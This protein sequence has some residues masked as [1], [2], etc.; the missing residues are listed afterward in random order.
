M[1]S[2][3]ISRIDAHKHELSKGQRK[4]TAYIT[5]HYDKAAF[6]TAAK[7]G[8]TVGVSES[9]V[10]RFADKLGY[11][12]YHKM[13]K[14]LHEMIRT[15]LTSVQRIEV[16]NDRIGSTDVLE[17]VMAADAER[18]RSTLGEID[19]EAFNTAVDKLVS[20]K[21]I[22]IIGVRSAA[23]LASFLGFYFNSIFANVTLISTAT[24]SE[25]FE[26]LL[27]IGEGDVALGISFPR[28]S[29]RTVSALRF[30]K[31]RGAHVIGITDSAFSPIA[32]TSTTT[33]IA[34]SDMASFVDS[35]CAPLSLIN[36]LIVAIGM[37]KS[38][39]ISQT[40]EQLE[41]IWD[42]YNVYQKTQQ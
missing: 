32:E 38:D 16:T 9:T 42:E 28:Y 40:F 33:L 11:D 30:A 35:L 25:M 37:R 2:E 20:A 14:A 27:R 19:R 41:R 17:A 22:Y 36:A 7:L 24:L 31:D 4:L 5:E 1:A 10:V 21:H 18:I 8:E 23:S 29:A 13:Q 34:R 15:K 6:M 12:G 3:L 26:Q 39:E